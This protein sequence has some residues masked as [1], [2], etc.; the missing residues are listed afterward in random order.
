MTHTPIDDYV[1]RALN[2]VAISP[3]L[4]AIVL[5][6]DLPSAVRTLAFLLAALDLTSF[7]DALSFARDYTRS[8]NLLVEAAMVW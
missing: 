7:S 1:P 2:G 4:Q 8:A 3:D 5:L 6:W